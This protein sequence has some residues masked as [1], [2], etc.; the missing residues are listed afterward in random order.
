M[1]LD[2]RENLMMTVI[3]VTTMHHLPSKGTEHEEYGDVS[4]RGEVSLLTLEVP[5]SH[6]DHGNV[7]RAPRAKYERVQQVRRLFKVIVEA[8]HHSGCGG[9]CV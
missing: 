5:Q 9:K 8:G 7:V 4:P 3:M 1:G 6:D 2:K